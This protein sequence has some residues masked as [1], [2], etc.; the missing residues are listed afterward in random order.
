MSNEEL[1]L[2]TFLQQEDGGLF[3][4]VIEDA[5]GEE[6]RLWLEREPFVKQ[7]AIVSR[8]DELFSHE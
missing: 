4:S 7:R 5:S 8:E 3:I 1:G 2:D 6:K